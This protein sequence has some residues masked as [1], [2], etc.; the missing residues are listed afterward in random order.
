MASVMR[1][2]AEAEL[3]VVFAHLQRVGHL[4]ILIRPTAVVIL[5]I[6]TAVLQPDAEVA[7]GLLADLKGIDVAPI[8]FAGLPLNAG[9]ATNAGEHAAEFV[10]HEPGDI[11]G[12]DATR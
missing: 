10:G 7:L 8:Q 5:E 4:Q 11:E 6:F 9:K 3:E 12:A 1:A 2:D